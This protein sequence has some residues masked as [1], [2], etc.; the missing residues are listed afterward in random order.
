LRT[1]IPLAAALACLSGGARAQSPLPGISLQGDA[2]RPLTPE[3]VERQKRIDSEY[4]AATKK[5]PNQKAAD[6]WGDVRQGPT[7]S[8]AKKKQQ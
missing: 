1:A 8:A 3:E 4:K 2:K 7:A 5:I 6:P